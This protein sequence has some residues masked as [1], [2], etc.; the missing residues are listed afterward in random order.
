MKYLLALLLLVFIQSLRAQL[1]LPG[2]V[3]PFRQ[4]ML[5]YPEVKG[6]DVYHINIIRESDMKVIYVA[7]DSTVA[8]LVKELLDFGQTYRCSVQATAA[9]KNLSQ[10]TVWSFSTKASVTS[11]NLKNT[12]TVYDSVDATDGLICLDYGIIINRK[13]ETVLC[14]PSIV[15]AV[16]HFRVNPNGRITFVSDFVAECNLEGDYLWKTKQIQWKNQYIG[17]FH[18][19]VGFVSG[20]NYLLLMTRKDSLNPM[21]SEDIVAEVDYKKDI[22]RFWSERPYNPACDSAGSFHINSIAIGNKNE[23]FLISC[24]DISSIICVNRKSGVPRYVIG[25]NISSSVPAFPQAN[26]EVQHAASFTSAGEVLLFNNGNRSRRGTVSSIQL[27]SSPKAVNPPQL[28]WEYKF[29]FALPEENFC[30]KT[31]SVEEVPNGNYLIAQGVWNRH[32]EVNR[33]K[34]I[35]WECLTERR[36]DSSAQWSKAG[37]FS[38]HYISSLYPCYFT[39]TLK[40]GGHL[41]LSNEGSEPDEYEIFLLKGEKNEKLLHTVSLLAGSSSRFGLPKSVIKRKQKIV[42]RSKTAGRA[43]QRIIA[44][45]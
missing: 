20:G 5:E 2:A 17:N 34:K 33:D 12:I 31:G 26:F 4:V 37:S 32:F 18:H 42:V 36:A 25:K 43:S 8:H 27:F 19:Q 39:A 1:P 22:V 10:L 11:N 3:I 40:E 9:G 7:S 24:R 30:A 41:L 38:A 14:H 6:A 45:N 23:D 29:N 13:G 35:V 28:L 15:D 44:S 21:S 16:R